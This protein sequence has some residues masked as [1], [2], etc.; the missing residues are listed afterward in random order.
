MMEFKSGNILLDKS[1]AIVNTVNCEGVCGAG[2]AKEFKLMY[3]DNFRAYAEFCRQNRLRPGKIC[4]YIIENSALYPPRAIFNL[5]TK[6]DWQRPSKMQWIKAGIAEIHLFVSTLNY[7]S[8]AIPALGCNNG[9]LNWDKVK[10]LLIQQFE[11]VPYAVTI[12]NPLTQD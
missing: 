10:L 12:Y 9:G 7:K 4:L 1:D 2:L 5:A 6:A 3:E 11:S 8:V